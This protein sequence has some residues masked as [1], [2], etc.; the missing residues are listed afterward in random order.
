ME[1]LEGRGL[2]DPWV[3]RLIHSGWKEVMIAMAKALARAVD[4]PH[5]S[6]ILHRHLK[7]A[8][9]S[10]AT[11]KDIQQNLSGIGASLSRRVI[12]ERDKR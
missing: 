7:K 9:R 4:R 5:I 1:A 6:S 11:L 3:A 10:D 8:R 12:E 2:L